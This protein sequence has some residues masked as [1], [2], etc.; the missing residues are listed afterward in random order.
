MNAMQQA[1]QPGR[2]LNA[3]PRVALLLA[4]VVACAALLGLAACGVTTSASGASGGAHS[5]NPG[6]PV[7]VG[8][9]VRPCSG[10]YASASS[11]APALVLTLKSQN[12]AGSA[13]VGQVVQ[14]QLP[15]T[16][17]WDLISVPNG[18]QL[19]GEAAQQDARQSVCFW[20]FKVAMA[21][22]YV[23]GFTGVT[24]CD[25]SVTLCQQTTDTERFTLT[26][27]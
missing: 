8:M 23:I 10:P 5:S 19:V 18:L 1:V 25:P 21:G 17:H 20:N 2:R 16:H 26:A 14:V 3:H 4:S 13:R 24:P 15:I 9:A 6:K 11:A 27:Q 22:K 7:N 12:Q